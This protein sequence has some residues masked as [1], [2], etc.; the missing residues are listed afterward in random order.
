MGDDNVG[1]IDCTT[2][3]C[4]EPPS[5]FSRLPSML[6]TGDDGWEPSGRIAFIV[7]VE[8]VYASLPAR[9]DRVYSCE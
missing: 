4:S 3:I 9:L 7:T 8:Q 5:E 1:G 2:S 6:E